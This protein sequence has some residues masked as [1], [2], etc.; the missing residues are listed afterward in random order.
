MK[1]PGRIG[2]A[3][4]YGSGCWAQRYSP[5]PAHTPIPF[6]H[7]DPLQSSTVSGNPPFSS[8]SLLFLFTFHFSFCL[9][10][11]RELSC[12]QYDGDGRADHANNACL[13]LCP[14]T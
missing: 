6:V 14:C 7:I 5:P 9:Y 1:F 10:K 4:V 12:V 11:H 8:P 2:E 3:A 13:E